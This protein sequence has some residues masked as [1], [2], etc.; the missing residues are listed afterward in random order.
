MGLITMGYGHLTIVTMG[1]GN[2]IIAGGQERYRRRPRL[3][4]VDEPARMA[5]VPVKDR[6]TFKTDNPEIETREDNPEI[7]TEE[8]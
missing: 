5:V 3:E 8:K 6:V 4:F 7:E 2:S 1:L